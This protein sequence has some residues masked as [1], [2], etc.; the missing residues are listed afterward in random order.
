MIRKMLL[1]AYRKVVYVVRYSPL[2][3]LKFL[4]RIQDSI[5]PLFVPR[6]VVIDGLTVFL[7][8]RDYLHLANRSFE[9]FESKTIMDNVK[10]GDVVIDIGAN[11]GFYT[12]LLARKVG[13]KGKV[14][15]FEPD[16]EMFALL[17][18]NVKANGFRNVKLF[19]MAVY[20]RSKTLS[21]S[22]YSSDVDSGFV[23]KEGARKVKA[24]SIDSLFA[25]KRVDFIKMDIEGSE[26]MAFKGMV[27]TA[28]KN[29]KIRIV[30]E[31]F[32]HLLKNH[33]VNNDRFYD[34]LKKEG[35]KLWDM[36]EERRKLVPLL[37]R[38]E[39]VD[40]PL[41]KGEIGFYAINMLCKR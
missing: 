18:K 33:S 37:K 13:P 31:F 15:A 30:T 29:P 40:R 41:Q 27:K 26:G 10:E 39:V 2:R 35:F 38:S 17:K 34:L 4:K 19:P 12:L 32:P 7:D 11:L 9:P 23:S 3:N 24:V 16:T 22:G 28:R 1:S 20:D 25:N 21:F 5:I 14:Y 36:D 6:S 8:K